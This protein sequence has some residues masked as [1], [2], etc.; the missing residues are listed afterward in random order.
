MIDKG[1][2][3]IFQKDNKNIQNIDIIQLKKK[4]EKRNQ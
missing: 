1:I 2:F 4:L 3:Q